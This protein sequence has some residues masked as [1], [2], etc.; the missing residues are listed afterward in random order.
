M[1]NTNQKFIKIKKN[2]KKMSKQKN[3]E[4]NEEDLIKENTG[5]MDNF[6]LYFAI[7]KDTLTDIIRFV[8]A[9]VMIFYIGMTIFSV[10]MRFYMHIHKCH[11]VVEVE[12]EKYEAVTRMKHCEYWLR[13][14][15]ESKLIE[16]AADAAKIGRV[17]CDEAVG[18]L[19]HWKSTL[20]LQKFINSY[21]ICSEE[22]CWKTFRDLYIMNSVGSTSVWWLTQTMMKVGGLMV[23]PWF[24]RGGF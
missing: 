2:I 18:K 11:Q 10:F 13:T 16:Y 22:G 8:G 23:N 1:L 15:P 21:S 20:I 12:L 19:N 6:I 24:A 3:V 7:I 9:C 5:L 4:P 14:V 17:D